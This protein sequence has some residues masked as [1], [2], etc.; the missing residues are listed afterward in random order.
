MQM[1][2]KSRLPEIM[3]RLF[4]FLFLLIQSVT[5]R[6]LM[7]TVNQILINQKVIMV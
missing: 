4:M 2:S 6:Q 3:C 7:N 1:L 5:V